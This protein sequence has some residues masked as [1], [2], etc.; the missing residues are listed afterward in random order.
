MVRVSVCLLGL[1]LATLVL[2]FSIHQV[3]A[4]WLVFPAPVLNPS[5]PQ[6]SEP[7]ALV[8]QA[9]RHAPGDRYT[10]TPHNRNGPRS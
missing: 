3:M 2:R 8:D 7:A 6:V 9:R 4:T 10:N 1:I 5:P